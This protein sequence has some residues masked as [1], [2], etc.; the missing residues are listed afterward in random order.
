MIIE[1]RPIHI[2]SD[3]L[4]VNFMPTTD[5]PSPSET[6]QDYSW[7]SDLPAIEFECADC[8]VASYQLDKVSA[9]LYG[10]GHKLTCVRVSGG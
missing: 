9:S 2:A 7:L 6:A 5:E 10:D 3:Y 4:R 8:K 1:A